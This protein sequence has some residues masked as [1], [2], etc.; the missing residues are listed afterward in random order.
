MMR[1]VRNLSVA[2][3]LRLIVA[4]TVTLMVG[5]ML[6]IYS[7]TQA[8][9]LRRN[10]I[11]ELL[12]L[13]TAV[14]DNLGTPL[15]RGNRP[16]A[17]RILESLRADPIIQDAALFDAEGR[18]IA[19]YARPRSPAAPDDQRPAGEAT[20]PAI[21]RQLDRYTGLSR[22]NVSIPVVAGGERVGTMDIDADLSS[23]YMQLRQSVRYMLIALF[24]AAALAYALSSRPRS[25]ISSPVRT[26]IRV[27]RHVS[28]K[29][30]F[31]IR[32]DKDTGGDFGSLIDGFNALLAELETRDRNLRVYKN[33]VEKKV[34]ERTVELDRAVADARNAAK[35]AED[36]S[37]AKSDFLARMSH[38][39][40]TPMNGV[41]GMSELL[42]HSPT[43][44]ERQRRYA[45][46]IHQS[47]TALLH[48]IND[49]LDF[50]KIEA[51]KLEL[52][53]ASFNL[54]DLVE[55]AVEIFAE[56][57]H[58]KGLELVCEMPDDVETDVYGDSQRLRQIIINLIGN[59][60]K[61]T[62]RG[63]IK[64]RVYE[65][66]ASLFNSSF[67]FEVIDSGIGIKAEN[68]STIFESFAQEDS[69][70]T[71]QYGGTG[72]GLAIC[73]QLVELMGGQ[74][75]VSS[76][77]G[78]GS[79]FFFSV[80]LPTNST[81]RE[82]SEACFKF[83]RMLI[84][85]DSAAN[86]RIVAGYL[87]A[88]GVTVT[89]AN[90][91]HEAL[92]IL[93]QALDSEYDALILDAEMERLHGAS[94]LDELERRPAFRV[95]PM[96]LMHSGIAPESQP[97]HAHRGPSA[98]LSKPIRR[99][100]LHACITRILQDQAVPL[101]GS[102]G[103]PPAVAA[104]VAIAPRTVRKARILLVE[105]NPVNVEVANAMLRE[106][107]VAADTA[108]SG[109]Q[110]LEMLTAARY[111]LV[112]MDCQM[113]KLDGY[114]TTIRF[115]AW[116]RQHRRERT[117]IIALTANAL[118][119]DDEKC[120]AAG[121]DRY[122]SK[123][124]TIEQ[125]SVV[126]EYAKADSVDVAEQVSDIAAQAGDVAKQASDIA[127]QTGM[128]GGA[129]DQR[130]VGRIRAL[131]RN[132]QPD[133]FAKVA[134]IYSENSRTLAHALQDA[135]SMRDCAALMR[136]AHALKSSSANIG[137]TSLAELCQQME[138]AAACGAIDSASAL[139][140]PLLDEHKRVLRALDDQT[141][142]AA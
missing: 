32:A 86:R 140:D 54:R 105:D 52:K 141:M 39:I 98:S 135:M 101:D 109:E 37:R 131:H 4:C 10:A 51:G 18:L 95:I 76:S 14:A 67:H 107:G 132:G 71:R 40:R 60:V 133:L 43:L 16:D 33:E 128:E 74:I 91:C 84:V 42:R 93:D 79:T 142:A 116:E 62:E 134:G 50:S 100:Q 28:E 8:Q 46:T 99:D 82:K 5:L 124:Y 45:V 97:L 85:D 11:Q 24:S 121:M 136:A 57:A 29:N 34:K 112:L 80:P 27:N 30:D 75:G 119:G 7:I 26:L 63:E 9:H 77:P 78:Q 21:R 115:R 65:S 106:L 113:P 1:W 53:K 35:R 48:I 139:A 22:S 12:T 36:A 73:K 56:R 137:A 19:A 96:I 72:L 94:L 108:W 61:F 126:L 127:A 58:S 89:E 69:S 120:F 20:A 104:D 102:A 55:D 3:Q 13:A 110:A 70:T 83:A 122:L 118:G 103:A 15:K 41:L 66:D 129:L 117:P 49:I 138:A 87:S 23:L 44:D 123:P 111:D 17:D 90:S 6:S 81:E 125:L 47:G 31:S 88:W 2:L 130:A 25:L 114:E 92:K 64:I 59:A 68:C 38:E